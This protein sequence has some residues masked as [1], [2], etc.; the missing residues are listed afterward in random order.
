VVFNGGICREAKMSKRDFLLVASTATICSTLAFF[1][2]ATL[3][4]RPEASR[5]ER[6]VDAASLAT[7]AS[8]PNDAVAPLEAARPAPVAADSSRSA[9]ATPAGEIQTD[10]N[11]IN[12]PTLAARQQKQLGEEFSAFVRNG[13]HSNPGALT[14]AVENRFYSEARNQE[15]AAAREDNIRNLFA[16]NEELNGLDPLDVTCRSKNCQVVLSA[17]TQDE[18]RTLSEKF[19]QV[20]TRSDVGMDRKMVA[21]FPDVTAGRLVFYLSEN[22][23]MDLFH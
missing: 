21:F 15:W 18:V 14:A 13:S 17:S 2:G 19:M 23:N 3:T 11:R 16:A 12:E 9:A 10:S 22:G 1:A 4:T 20:A 6:A 5:S 8:N 7:A